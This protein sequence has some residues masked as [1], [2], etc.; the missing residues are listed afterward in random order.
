MSKFFTDFEDMLEF[1]LELLNKG[2]SFRVEGHANGNT[3]HF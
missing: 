2:K 3:V 1:T